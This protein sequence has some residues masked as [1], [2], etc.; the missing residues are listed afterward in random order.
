MKPSIT[1]VLVCLATTLTL[2]TRDAAAATEVAAAVA[3]L[4]FWMAWGVVYLAIAVGL[5]AVATA[6]A[7]GER[8]AWLSLVSWTLDDAD[9]DDAEPDSSRDAA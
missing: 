3:A 1:V 9:V 7:L 6:A 8:R 5:I 2:T 4:S